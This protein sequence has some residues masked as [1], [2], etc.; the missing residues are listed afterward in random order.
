MDALAANLVAEKRVQKQTGE[1][2]STAVGH[3]P[4]FQAR[5]AE[6]NKLENRGLL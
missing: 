3:A 4:A 5:D 2:E 6:V 1:A